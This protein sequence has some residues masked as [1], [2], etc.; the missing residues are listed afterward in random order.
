MA[1]ALGGWMMIPKF[2]IRSWSLKSIK[3]T[4][5]GKEISKGVIR[6][7]RWEDYAGSPGW[8]LNTLKCH[9]SRE[10]GR[11]WYGTA[12]S[13]GF[14]LMPQTKKNLLWCSSIFLKVPPVLLFPFNNL[15]DHIFYKAPVIFF[16]KDVAVQVQKEPSLKNYTAHNLGM[17]Q[18][19]QIQQADVK[20]PDR[21]WNVDTQEPFQ[22]QEVPHTWKSG[23][24][25][26]LS[27]WPDFKPLQSIFPWSGISAH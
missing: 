1:G 27:C 17:R 5:C 10:R 7:L 14:P 16:F 12:L 24:T 3:V 21:H 20:K 11:I 4:L 13:L 8:S 15:S 19:R 18:R 6:I 23:S 22:N 26:F 2:P 25:F 9:Y